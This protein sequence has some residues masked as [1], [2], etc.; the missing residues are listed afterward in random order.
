M[1]LKI[2]S[3]MRFLQT[4]IYF[5]F[6]GNL[7]S[8]YFNETM[9]QLMDTYGIERDIVQEEIEK[10]LLA[11][12]ERTM[13]PVLKQPWSLL[14]DMIFSF[15][16][17]YGQKFCRMWM[18]NIGC[19]WWLWHQR[20]EEK[21]SRINHVCKKTLVLPNNSTCY[22]LKQIDGWCLW[23]ILDV[24]TYSHLLTSTKWQTEYN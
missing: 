7:G 24:H 8:A 5:L 1:F 20:E 23:D 14:T 2:Q 4:L 22:S 21:G 12:P 18:I 15:H 6:F 9:A 11:Y 17:V 3:W 19:P 10:V 13:R 16:F